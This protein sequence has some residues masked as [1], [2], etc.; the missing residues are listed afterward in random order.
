M[1]KKQ[2]PCR[3][4]GD[5]VPFHNSRKTKI[6]LVRYTRQTSN[7]WHFHGYRHIVFV[8]RGGNLENRKTLD[9]Q[10]GPGKVLTYESGELHRNNHVEDNSQNLIIEF[11]DMFF[12][13][14]SIDFTDIDKTP[15]SRIA[16]LKIYKECSLNDNHSPSELNEL[17]LTLFNKAQ[18]TSSP[19]WITDVK[20]AINDRWYEFIS[21][22]DLAQSVSLHPVTISKQFL[23]HTGSTITEYQRKIKLQRAFQLLMTTGQPISD[24][25]FTCGF[26]DQSHMTRLFRFYTGFTPQSLREL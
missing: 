1:S 14:A 16:L 24:I 7:E 2:T 5:I 26:S 21:L 23:R 15:N 17:V 20:A 11:N 22:A 10:A 25:A 6:S 13:D 4:V 12:K 8:L 3:Y 18:R 19:K 9:I